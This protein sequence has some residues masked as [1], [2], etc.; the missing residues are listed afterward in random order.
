[1]P[2][3]IKGYLLLV[4]AT[5]LWGLSGAVSKYFFNQAMSPL[6]LAMVRLTGSSLLLMPF[7][8]LSNPSLLHLDRGDIKRLILFGIVGIGC[9]QFSYLFTISRLN[10]A[11]AVF[12][13]YLA[14]VFIAIYAVWWKKESLGRPGVTALLLALVGSSLIIAGQALAGLLHYWIGLLSGFAAGLTFAFYILYGKML[15][16][17]Y[18]SWAVL[19]Y[20][21]LFGAIP[22]WFLAPPWM[23]WHQHYGWQTWI[24][25]GYIII[26]ATLIPFGLT[27]MGLRYLKPAPASITMML[28]PV[29]AGV[30]AFLLLG[31][32]L[33]GM[34]L[35]GCCLI[36]GAVIVL[37]L[38][39]KPAG[40]H[41]VSAS[42]LEGSPGENP[43]GSQ[44]ALRATGQWTKAG[45]YPP[46]TNEPDVD[47]EPGPE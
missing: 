36:L 6:I 31:E 3:Q 17:R 8:L 12:L 41:A 13:E 27:L 39:Q 11:T 4:S 30:F 21:E 1:M 20:G 25:F 7:L 43:A 22:F 42:Y 38:E 5:I 35:V 9:V 2:K 15:L 10:V 14:P 29:M 32:M 28:E 47:Y 24:F 40:S 16:G 44:A 46:Q 33:N 34:Q 37:N 45:R 26:F 19:A 18:N 23:L